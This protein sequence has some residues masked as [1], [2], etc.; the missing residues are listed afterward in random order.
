MRAPVIGVA[1]S[2][3]TVPV[4]MQIVG[5]RRRAIGAGA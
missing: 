1:S 5:R 2:W 3:Q 4:S